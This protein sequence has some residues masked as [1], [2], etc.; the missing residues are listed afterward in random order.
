MALIRPARAKSFWADAKTT[1]L[2]VAYTCPPNCTAEITYLHVV[3]AGGNNTVSVKWYVSAS[4]Y[5]SNFV[6]GK[7]LATGEFIT[8]S[9]MTIYLASGD[10]ITI[11]T[12]TAG[13]L[14]LVGSV[15]ET[16]VPTQ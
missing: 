7:N 4:A 11:Q 10:Q 12:T 6:G 15:I 5:S 1:D 14:D 13:H 8:F 16:F 9:P 2:I 3:N